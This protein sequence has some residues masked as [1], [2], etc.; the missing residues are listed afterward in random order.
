MN[1]PWFTAPPFLHLINFEHQEKYH[2]ARFE[3]D[4]R[5]YVIRL[6]TDLFDEW[7]ITLING[8]IKSRLGQS[9]IQAF[10]SFSDA[11]MTFCDMAKVRYQRGYHLET[12]NSDVPLFLHTLF[13]LSTI[14]L[15]AEIEDKKK[16]TAKPVGTITMKNRTTSTSQ[17][18]YEQMG[19]GF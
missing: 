5:Y 15:P 1:L 9:R 18:K 11:Y 16:K 17:I 3:K 2:A 12:L 6:E 19:F 8:R 7:T 10:P 14:T 4:T 13:F